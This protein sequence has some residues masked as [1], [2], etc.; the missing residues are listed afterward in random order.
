[1]I[2]KIRNDDPPNGFGFALRRG[3][4]EFRCDVVAIAILMADGSHMISTRMAWLSL[5][6]PQQ[7]AVAPSLLTEQGY[8]QGP[9]IDEAV[10]GPGKADGCP[11]QIRP[12]N[13][14]QPP[15]LTRGGRRRRRDGSGSQ[16]NAGASI[17]HEHAVKA[18]VGHAARKRREQCRLLCA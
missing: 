1:L 17:S 4:A 5:K 16:M 7:L 8:V 2:G 18:R 15:L 12:V 11:G 13:P 6:S 14:P 10:P 9:E 3:F